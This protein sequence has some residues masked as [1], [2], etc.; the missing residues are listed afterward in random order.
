M[1]KAIP[2]REGVGSST[3]HIILDAAD[4]E[5]GTMSFGLANAI[6]L[7]VCKSHRSSPTAW[8]GLSS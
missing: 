5:G 3:N 8:L 1:V 6:W 4:I 2:R 7:A